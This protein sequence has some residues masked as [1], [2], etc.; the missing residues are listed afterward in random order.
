MGAFQSI[1][2]YEPVLKQGYFGKRPIDGRMGRTMRRLFVL[3]ESLLEWYVP[4]SRNVEGLAVGSVP[5][6]S[7]THRTADVKT[8]GATAVSCSTT[9]SLPSA[10]CCTVLDPSRLVTMDLVG[11]S[12]ARA[13]ASASRA[14]PAKVMVDV[15][16]GL[17]KLAFRPA[18]FPCKSRA[19]VYFRL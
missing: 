11:R 7:A 18:T 5:R 2:S 13:P 12:E 3:R 17:V 14:A 6:G 4:G 19:P 8:S 10:S 16:A 15:G 9:E 1:P